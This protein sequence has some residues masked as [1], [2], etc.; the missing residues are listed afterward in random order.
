[1]EQDKIATPR[2][3]TWL[4]RFMRPN[5]ISDLPPALFSLDQKMAAYYRSV[6]HRH[7][8]RVKR[9]YENETYNKIHRYRSAVT[10]KAG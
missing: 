4:I 6:A 1:M 8:E 5:E 2:S 10:R 3:C 7:Q 9:N